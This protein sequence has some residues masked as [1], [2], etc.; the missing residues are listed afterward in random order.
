MSFQLNERAK[1][2]LFALIEA[3]NYVDKPWN[4]DADDSNALL[5]DPPNWTEYS[6]F[7]LG[8]DDTAP[9]QTKA[10]YAYVFAKADGK[11]YLSALRQTIA[12]AGVMGDGAIADVA[13][14][15]IERA[16]AKDADHA[17]ASGYD[18]HRLSRRPGPRSDKSDRFAV[19]EGLAM[20][21]H[22]SLTITARAT[23]AGKLQRF[24]MVAYTGGE[25]R[26][27]RWKFPVVVDLE[28]LTGLDK[29]RPILRDHD[30]ARLVGH[31]D[32]FAII[33]GELHVSGIISGAGDDA[34]EVA[35]SSLNGLPWQASIGA[36][37]LSGGS[38]F[39]PA[40]K[41]AQANG[42]TFEGPLFI[43]R[44]AKLGEVSFVPMG[45]DDNTSAQVSARIA[46]SAVTT[47]G[48]NGGGLTGYV[49]SQPILTPAVITAAGCLA[50][51]IDARELEAE[52][53]PIV[54]DAADRLHKPG[55]N[56]IVAACFEMKYGRDPGPRFGSDVIQAALTTE[57]L[58]SIMSNVANRALVQ[59]YSAVGAVCD[60][61]CAID[62]IDRMTTATRVRITDAG[63]FEDV[64]AG[65][66][67]HPVRLGDFSFTLQ[68]RTQGRILTLGR[69][70]IYN[71]DMG[72]FLELPK[73]IGRTAAIS[74]EKILF[75]L[76]LANAGSFFGAAN[77]NYLS[78]AGTALSQ[79]S[80]N[81]A[82]Q[83]FREQKDDAGS[84]LMQTP[85]LLMV[86]P[87]LEGAAM[88]LYRNTAVSG[89]STG[90]DS[91]V[92]EG[93]E[94][95]VARFKP[96][97]APYLSVAGGLT[98]ASDA[99]WYLLGHVPDISPFHIGYLNGQRYPKMQQGSVSF[100]DLSMSFVAVYDFAIG[101][102]DPK[103]A[104][105]SAGA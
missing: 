52:Y 71:D 3:G 42:R 7:F 67:L 88:Q 86:P 83:K 58:G 57:S 12:A 33:N 28:G 25:M 10:R 49:P 100:A 61:V 5:G 41:S 68:P 24:T 82:A 45:A 76:I 48:G 13:R 62:S 43:A 15:A 55:I 21:A 64:S 34:A 20:D 44:Q 35:Q 36:R 92:A 6:N 59:S 53:G 18:H 102:A 2:R 75:G 66:E 11:V 37:I 40:G 87:A 84:L 14:Q 69:D 56:R 23:T 60:V 22:R 72:A 96:T 73:I 78:G 104:V 46:A 90:T 70:M 93:G 31:A 85:R 95:F 16:R 98:N 50:A 9:K 47:G 19:G 29:P 17:R 91:P 97:T 54:M 77:N 80:L 103:A 94:P 27:E 63:Y 32:S 4:F 1:V 101:L 30:P 81:T 74:K 99:G 65:G 89:D 8:L 51:G 105:F 39:V 79:T 26:L 38:E